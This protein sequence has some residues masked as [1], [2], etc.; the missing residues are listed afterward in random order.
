[1][2]SPLIATKLYRPQCQSGIVERTRLI[3]RLN[4]GLDR[5]MTLV[6]APAGFGKTTL[7]CDWLHHIDL[8]SSWLSLDEDDNDIHLFLN[9]LVA[10][11]E[12][13]QPEFG[14]TLKTTLR[15]PH[16]PP[17]RTVIASLINEIAVELPRSILLLDDYQHI[18]SPEVHEA[19]SL[20]LEHLPPNLHLVLSSRSDPPLPLTRLRT[21]RQINELRAADLR[22]TSDEAV[23]FLN[24][25]MGLN[26]SADDAEALEL[27]TEGWIASLQLAAIAIQGREDVKG[28]ITAFTGSHSYIVDY[29]TEEVFQKQPADVQDFLLKT[30]VLRSIS[31][32]LCNTVTGRSDGAEMLERLRRANLFI[33]PLD[34]SRQW[35]RYHHL[36][37]DLI[38]F[39]LEA[40]APDL[41]PE[42][43]RRAGAWLAEHD[44]LE[45]ALGHMLAAGDYHQAAAMIEKEALHMLTQGDVTRLK[46]WIAPLPA[47]VRRDYPYINICMAWITGI[48]GERE[49]I[50]SH[51]S[52]AESALDRAIPQKYDEE[53]ARVIRQH[54][55]TLRSYYKITFRSSNTEEQPKLLE[56]LA[57]ARTE[58]QSAPPVLTSTIES[59]IGDLLAYHGRWEEAREA[60]TSATLLGKSCGNLYAALAAVRNHARLLILI[61]ELGQAWNLCQWNLKELREQGV[62]DAN[63][64]LGHLFEPIGK[65]LYE[66]NDLP[67]AAGCLERTMEHGNQLHNWTMTIHGGL[68]LL[69]LRQMQGEQAVATMLMDRLLEMADRVATDF[70]HP[71]LEAR[72]TRLWLAQ[73]KLSLAERWA[74]GYRAERFQPVLF[75]EER[76]FA[77]A[78]VLVRAG[79]Y[80]DA[81]AVLDEMV[82]HARALKA[83][84]WQI[85]ALV[86]RAVTGYLQGR[87][88][89]A[90]ADM[91]DALGCAAPEGYIRTI[92]DEGETV[93]E[94]LVRLLNRND[95]PAKVSTAQI[96]ML[97]AAMNH[98][99]RPQRHQLI[100]AL[101]E[102]EVEVLRLLASGFS[103]N[104][105]ADRLY[106]AI[107]TVKKHTHS[108]YSKLSVA[109]RTQA[110]QRARELDLL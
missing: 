44:M 59:I 71:L 15:L 52:D 9:Y 25:T 41:V 60:F 97:L 51:L 72:R 63:P 19:M 34:E 95:R 81:R 74:E 11:L 24:R 40:S 32:P 101:T 88:D 38:R 62:D 36:F 43:H 65:I 110:I 14:A 61:G 18:G 69:W 48:G 23:L 68:S 29:L 50:L 8:P 53:G 16:L 93:S 57:Q 26:L 7:L 28:F 87:I 12:K 106:L 64:L 83:S 45:N 105:I 108:I 73:E 78:K 75:R 22:F 42:L 30:S 104:A 91:A 2:Q 49:E 17:V 77:Y 20:L 90:L 6:S 99:A 96:T 21:N 5:R 37:G 31:A 3:E 109:S 10:A 79:E 13:V 56:D 33:I 27:R 98:G 84:T 76:E 47:E 89:G 102:R 46:R 80:S 92:V 100:D 1:M 107:G 55:S 66:R 103:N 85:Q 54:V 39:R 70:W 67:E 94:L 35:Y 86:L 82:E 4:S 58:L